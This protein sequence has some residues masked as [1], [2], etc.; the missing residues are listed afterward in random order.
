MSQTPRTDDECFDGEFAM[1]GDKYVP[2]DFARQ[3]ERELA[4]ARKDARSIERRCKAAISVLCEARDAIQCITTLQLK[5]HG[6]SPTLADRMD[7]VGIRERWEALDA[8][9]SPPA[10]KG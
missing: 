8:A 7:D 10:E 3:L 4:E 9:M 1:E 5:M 6:I 2:A